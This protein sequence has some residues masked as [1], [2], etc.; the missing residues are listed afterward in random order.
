MHFTRYHCSL[1]YCRYTD[2]KSKVLDID[3]PSAEQFPEFYNAL[4]HECVLQPGDVL[5]IPGWHTDRATRNLIHRKCMYSLF[6]DPCGC[7]C[8]VLKTR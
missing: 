2:D 7:L 6:Q 5:F 4:Q 8:D 3:S 1:L